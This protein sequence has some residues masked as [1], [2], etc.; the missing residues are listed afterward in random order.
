MQTQ[1]RIPISKTLIGIMLTVLFLGFLPVQNVHAAT[2]FYVIPGGATSGACDWWS[3]G[4]DLQ[5]ALSI[6]SAGSEIWAKAGTYK[7]TI[8]TDRSAS[9][10][11]KSGVALYGGF[12]GNETYLHDRNL[13]AN[14]TILSGE[15]GASGISDNSYSVVRGSGTDA[16]A[17]LDGFTVTGG[18][19]TGAANY[20]GGG[21][22]NLTGS[23]TITNVIFSGNSSDQGGG[24]TNYNNSN[25]ILTNVTFIGNNGFWGGGMY[26][27]YS[28]PTL[29]NVTFSSNSSSNMDGAHGGGM[30]N[31]NSS[32]ALRNVTFIGNSA[33]E[34]DGMYNSENSSPIIRNSILWGNTAQT[35]PVILN[36]STSSPLITYS[37][38]QGGYAGTGNINTDPRLG[39]LGTYGGNI[40]VYPLLPGSPAIDSGD[41]ATCASTDTRGVSRPQNGVCD[42]GAFEGAWLRLGNHQR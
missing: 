30:A 29:T 13:V 1:S 35:V 9:F 41:N 14:L 3:Y 31:D 24:M 12:A 25:P 17:I 18:S 27:K 34:G 11:L 15:I 38:I 21:M 2:V 32:P 4:C 39:S 7:P 6:A 16:S 42:M 23:P 26:N 10:L 37:D 33:H 36:D 5:Y 40:Q 19:Y 8:G 28:S 20:V 22:T